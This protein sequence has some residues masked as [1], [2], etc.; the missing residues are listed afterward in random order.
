MS[1]GIESGDHCPG[2]GA[3]LTGVDDMSNGEYVEGYYL[4]CR[5]PRHD[6][7]ATRRAAKEA[8]HG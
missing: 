4:E 8:D 5:N 2:C 6:M 3:F 1:G 7:V